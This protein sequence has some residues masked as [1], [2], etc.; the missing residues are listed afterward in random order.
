MDLCQLLSS[1][2]QIFNLRELR[3]EGTLLGITLLRCVFYFEQLLNST[4]L[5]VE[6]L[7][8]EHRLF[9]SGGWVL[10]DWRGTIV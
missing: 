1:I 9:V 7:V 8:L 3:I 5:S 4:I 6:W 10:D 2:L